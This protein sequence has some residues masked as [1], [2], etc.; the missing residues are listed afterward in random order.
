M[1]WTWSAATAPARP[2]RTARTAPVTVLAAAGSPAPPLAAAVRR[3]ALARPAART[4]AG[5]RWGPGRRGGP[6]RPRNGRA[7]ARGAQGTTS[8]ASALLQ[9]GQFLLRQGEYAAALAQMQGACRRAHTA[10]DR[11]L[12]ADSLHGQAMAQVFMGEF[13]DAQASFEAALAEALRWI[14]KC[15]RF[16]SS[17]SQIGQELRRLVRVY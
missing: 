12:G 8:E 17:S 13:D 10:G 16:V 2:E 14:V 11:S 6:A 9:H 5:A 15:R 4:A 7:T 3:S 1:C